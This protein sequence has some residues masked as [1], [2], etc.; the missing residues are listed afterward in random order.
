MA[1]LKLPGFR[2]NGFQPFWPLHGQEVTAGMGLFL[3]LKNVLIV[4]LEL[5]PPIE[6]EEH[7]LQYC[8]RQC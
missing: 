7:Q 1:Q 3:L 4:A 8:L 6:S 5:L 2:K